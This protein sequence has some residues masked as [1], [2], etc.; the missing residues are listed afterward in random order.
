MSNKHRK[1]CLTSLVMQTETTVGY[2]F[3]PTSMTIITNMDKAKNW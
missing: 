2:H 1:I 3:T